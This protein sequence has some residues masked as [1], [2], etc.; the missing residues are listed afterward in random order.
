MIPRAN[1]TNRETQHHQLTINVNCV[2]V[3]KHL[4]MVFFLT[5]EV[6][7][8]IE[9]NFSHKKIVEKYSLVKTTNSFFIY[10][11][12]IL[13]RIS[14]FDWWELKIDLREEKKER[15]Y[16]VWDLDKKGKER[17]HKCTFFKNVD[18]AGA[19]VISIYY[20]KDTFKRWYL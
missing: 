15:R 2:D 10:F 11:N 5:C 16:T 3:I 18:L 12:S 8:T 6:L 9:L 14:D 17:H 19:V 4:R 7:F 1:V 13:K 20:I